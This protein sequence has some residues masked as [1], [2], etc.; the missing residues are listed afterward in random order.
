MAEMHALDS[1]DSTTLGSAL[2]G[3]SAYFHSR[4]LATVSVRSLTTSK[5]DGET[6]A[7]PTAVQSDGHRVSRPSAGRAAALVVR[8]RIWSAIF[9][10]TPASA[11]TYC[12]DRFDR[13]RNEAILVGCMCILSSSSGVGFRSP[14]QMMFGRSLHARN[15]QSALGVFLHMADRLVLVR[16][17]EE[18]L[19]AGNREE[20]QHMAARN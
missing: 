1:P 19:T 18:F 20:C 11:S 3:G 16:I 15:G 8:T 14:A 5:A 4:L 13:I 17:E 6:R 12:H 9:E 10:P 2:R 7:G